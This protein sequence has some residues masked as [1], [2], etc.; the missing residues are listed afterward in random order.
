M[1]VVI[2]GDFG[3]PRPC[4]GWILHV[5]ILRNA[6]KLSV[7]L[8]GHSPCHVQVD[9]TYPSLMT[10]HCSG[11]G[12]GNGSVRIVFQHE[13]VFRLCRIQRVN[14]GHSTSSDVPI[15]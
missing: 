10:F 6:G 11:G 1:D 3:T 2:S 13:V 14:I 7:R 4:S 8:I 5:N 15:L 12:G 9:F